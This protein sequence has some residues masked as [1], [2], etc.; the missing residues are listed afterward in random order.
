[1][2]RKRAISRPKHLLQY[3]SVAHF[4]QTEDT[5]ASH[6]TLCTCFAEVRKSY[7]LMAFKERRLSRFRLLQVG[8]AFPNDVFKFFNNFKQEVFGTGCETEPL[9]KR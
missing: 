6:I 7:P 4:C 2:N 5:P 3:L 1:M 8:Q 9:M